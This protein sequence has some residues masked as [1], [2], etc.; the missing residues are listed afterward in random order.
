M[1]VTEPVE[2]MVGVRL[3]DGTLSTLPVRVE[4][5]RPWTVHL[6]QHSHT[7]IGYTRTQTEILAEQVRYALVTNAD[8]GNVPHGGQAI[9][10]NNSGE[11]FFYRT[12]Q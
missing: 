9:G 7:D 2:E 3:P 11:Q 4:P 12:P 5:V 6:V 10:G 8:L 1:P